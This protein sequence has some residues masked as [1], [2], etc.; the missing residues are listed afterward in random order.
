[1]L[2]NV[3]GQAYGVKMS[4][5]LTIPFVSPLHLWASGLLVLVLISSSI[6]PAF[7]EGES[8]SEPVAEEA[9]EPVAEPEAAPAAE[10]E[11]A[12]E[13]APAAEPEAAPAAEPE[14]SYTPPPEAFEGLGG[15]AVVDPNTGRVHG[16][17]V[18]NVTSQ[19]Q[20]EAN[21]ARQAQSTSSYMGCPAPC[22]LRFQT[23]AT[24]DGNVAGWH[25]ENVIWDEA[26][27][28][29]NIRNQNQGA[30]TSQ[31]LV[32]ART[33][34]D[35]AGMDL[36]TGLVDIT[37]TVTKEANGESADVRIYRENYADS[38][39]DTAV[40]YPSLGPEG[41]RFSY[42]LANK[43]AVVPEE[44]PVSALSQLTIDVD[45]VLMD[46]GYTTTETVVDEDTGVETEVTIV[47]AEDPF[48]AAI[49]EVT[50]AVVEFLTSFFGFG[51]D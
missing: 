36:S 16:V 34:R 51:E 3:G 26:S 31:T 29:F 20:Y 40:D 22:V 14:P 44:E 45:S 41:R 28:T 39:Q 47:D 10:P 24:A 23:R 19:E 18:G 12:P 42:V 32:P 9:S 21:A 17:I 7:A 49:R 37:T 6:A 25:G 48:V 11:A 50:V 30:T 1:L 27:G 5:K 4:K 2:A 35:E 46:E 8:E 15:W 13:A 38:T 43:S 33:A